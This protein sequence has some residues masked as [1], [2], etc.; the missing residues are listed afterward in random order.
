[1]SACVCVCVCVCVIFRDKN[2]SLVT[3][4]VR[5]LPHHS[6]LRCLCLSLVFEKTEQSFLIS[7]ISSS[8]M[9]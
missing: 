6:V 1:M 4:P 9:E 7:S 3:H 2:T 5:P 8:F